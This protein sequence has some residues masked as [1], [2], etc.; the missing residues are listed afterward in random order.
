MFAPV[1]VACQPAFCLLASRFD[2][3]VLESLFFRYLRRNILAMSSHGSRSLGV[4][5][6][7]VMFEAS[8]EYEIMD[9]SDSSLVSTT[10]FDV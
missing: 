8:F 10:P 3:R 9:G 5:D 2:W 1:S 7:A 6:G 4:L